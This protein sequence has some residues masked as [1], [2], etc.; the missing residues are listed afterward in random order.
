MKGNISY[1]GSDLLR[2]AVKPS[3][4]VMNS[5]NTSGSN[6]GFLVTAQL[7]RAEAFENSQLTHPISLLTGKL[8]S[9]EPN[10]VKG[11]LLASQIHIQAVRPSRQRRNYLT[12]PVL[13]MKPGSLSLLSEYVNEAFW[14]AFIAKQQA[15][16]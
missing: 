15:P 4:H 6:K 11:G 7:L 1:R 10:K 16:C 8:P 2:E 9:Q 3:A 12:F 5:G 13:L 14:T